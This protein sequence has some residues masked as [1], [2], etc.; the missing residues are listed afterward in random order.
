VLAGTGAR[1]LS[2]VAVDWQEWP[3]LFKGLFWKQGGISFRLRQNLPNTLLS[4]TTNQNDIARQ[5][6]R[7]DQTV[8][9]LIFSEA[10]FDTAQASLV[11]TSK[12]ASPQRV[13][14]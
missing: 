13:P 2:F 8:K 3:L 5:I 10:F 4:R 1:F 11:L 9:T 6:E 14:R 12:N 7:V